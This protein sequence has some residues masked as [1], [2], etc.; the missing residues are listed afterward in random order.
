M[1]GTVDSTICSKAASGR[2]ASR[3]E[4]WLQHLAKLGLIR[5]SGTVHA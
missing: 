5:L 4:Q 3:K 2:T 1:F